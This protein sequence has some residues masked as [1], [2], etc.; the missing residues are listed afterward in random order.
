MREHHFPEIV[1]PDGKSRCIHCGVAGPA[2]D[3][4][5]LERPDPNAAQATRPLVSAAQD[6]DAI[7][8]RIKELKTANDAVLAN[9]PA[10]DTPKPRALVADDADAIT[11]RIKELRNAKDT[12]LGASY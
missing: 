12:S 4:T 7:N 1:G 8:A 9:S 3:A 2:T 11:T 6:F 5:C 10:A